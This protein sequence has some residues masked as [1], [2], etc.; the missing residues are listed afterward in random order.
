[1]TALSVENAK[2]RTAR[3]EVPDAACVGLWLI[4]QPSGSKSWAVRYR[5]RGQPRKMTIGKVEAVPLA[6]ARKAATAALLEVSQG[7]DPCS[8]KKAALAASQEAAELRAADSVEALAARFIAQH[9]ETKN[10][11]NT[12]RQVKQIFAVE[13]LPRWKHLTVH[14]ITKRHVVALIDAIAEDR[15]TLANRARAVIG[16]W[17]NWMIARDVVRTL[18]PVAGVERPA[19]ENPRERVLTEAE[20]SAL[21]RA[22]G[23]LGS[24]FATLVKLLLLTGQ[25]RNE[26]AFMRW[27]EIDI[28]KR[29]WTL[30]SARSKNKKQ[31]TIPL[32]RQVWKII[33]GRKS[34]DLVLDVKSLSRSKAALDALARIPHW[35]LHDCRRTCV[36]QMAEI[37]IAPH[38]IEATVNHIGGHKAGIAGVYNRAEY[39]DEKRDAL[40]AWAN[41][42]DT[43]VGEAQPSNNVVRLGAQRA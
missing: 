28:E 1:M 25:R 37:G 38:I 15:P 5:F 32:S 21:W 23:L 27:S 31:H 14:D 2:P 34:G 20:I 11:P 3:Y 26:I 29:L 7:R 6:A 13:I 39:A 36:T 30:P 41:H 42:I 33:E 17:Y 4:I 19:P 22:C 18:S 9:V 40:Q 43:I 35:T 12:I 24:D 10:R 16:K 8:D